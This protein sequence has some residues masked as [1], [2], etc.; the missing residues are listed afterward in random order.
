MSATRPSGPM[1]V[2]PLTLEGSLIRLEP[3]SRSHLADLTEAATDA[4][5]WRWMA[6]RNDTPAAMRAWLDRAM[7]AGEAQLP[8]ATI[9]R[10]SS[11]AVGS[12]RY[13]AIERSHRRLEIGWTWLAATARG[14]GLNDEAKLLLLRHAFETLGCQRVEFKTDARNE[15]SRGALSGIGATYDGTF[16]KHMLNHDG[17]VRDSAWYRVLDDE[18]PSVER[19]LEERL[20]PHRAAA[21]VAD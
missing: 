20:A 3:L 15:R 10:S 9:E 1:D 5:V 8:F 18:W 2:R 4:S 13:L 19:R 21:G 7:Q 11:R 6:E 14:R 17:R 16:Q 12:T